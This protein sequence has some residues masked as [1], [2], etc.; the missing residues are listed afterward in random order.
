MKTLKNPVL[1]VILST[2][3]ISLSEFIRN[4]FVFKEYWV[5]HY[6][7]LG[8][9][10]PS[11]P[12]NGAVWGLWSLV[13]AIILY[14]LFSR[15][16]LLHTTMLG[17]VLGFV[18]MWLVIGNMGVLPYSLLIYAIPLSMLEVWVAVLIIRYFTPKG[19]TE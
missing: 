19:K 3:W 4:E 2:V 17:W 7:S 13:F 18:L 9:V 8:I 16:N 10:F 12:V 6:T 5:Q 15:F 11:E 1:P 14:V